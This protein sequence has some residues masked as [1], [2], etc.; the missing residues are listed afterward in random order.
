MR[1]FELQSYEKPFYRNRDYSND[2]YNNKI[3]STIHSIQLFFKVRFQSTSM[4]ERAKSRDFPIFSR[5]R[6]EF[7]RRQLPR[8]KKRHMS[9]RESP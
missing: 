8:P 6:D 2:G 9:F 3:I 4:V 7:L 5:K 1:F